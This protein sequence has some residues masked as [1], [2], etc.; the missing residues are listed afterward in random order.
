MG[1]HFEVEIVGDR[2]IKTPT[3][4]LLS[5][6]ELEEWA[7]V[8]NGL[9]DIPGIQPVRLEDGR[10]VEPMAPGAELASLEMDVDDERVRERLGRILAEVRQ[11]GYEIGNV[12]HG[13]V[14]Y[15]GET[16]EVTIVDLGQLSKI[17]EGE[18]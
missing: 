4:L 15:D 1:A 12:H 16:G 10:V 17:G 14:F 7:E 9:S 6:W 2:V 3:P 11:R 8:V 18:A 13:N 5:M